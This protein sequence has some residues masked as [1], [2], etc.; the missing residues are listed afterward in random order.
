MLLLSTDKNVHPSDCG[1]CLPACHAYRIQQIAWIEPPCGRMEQAV[2]RA[3]FRFLEHP[4]HR[5]CAD[6]ATDSEYFWEAETLDHGNGPLGMALWEWQPLNQL[7]THLAP[8]G[9]SALYYKTIRL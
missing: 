2:G 4:M 6:L 1:D 8:P 7:A 5:R 3:Q 9:P